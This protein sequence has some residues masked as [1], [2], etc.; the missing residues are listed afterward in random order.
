MGVAAP[1]L[2]VVG[3]AIEHIMTRFVQI[4]MIRLVYENEFEKFV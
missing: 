1:F 3:A 4:N 2:L